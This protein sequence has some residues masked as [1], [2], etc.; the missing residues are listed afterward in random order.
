MF[1]FTYDI[2]TKILFGKGQIE[3]LGAE[4]K[5]YTDSVLLVYGGGSIKKN[6]VY[7]AAVKQLNDY[8]IRFE[9]LSGVAPNPRIESVVKGV[10]II[11]KNDLKGVL[12]VGGGSSIDCAKVIAGSVDYDG[13]PWD[14]VTAKANYKNILPIFS[15]LTLS[16]TGSEMDKNAVI[17][18]TELNAKVGTFSYDFLPKV[19]VM[20]PTY[21]FT[22][23]KEQTAAGTAD[24]MSHIME[25]YFSIDES[26]YISDRFAEGLLRA[27]IK[28]API[29]IENPEDYEARANLMWASTLGI[30]GITSMGKRI[31]WS[32]HRIEHMLSAYYDI[33]H[34]TGLAILTPNWMQ[35][36]LNESTLPRFVTYG[37]N[38]WDI[39]ASLSKE[40]IAKEAIEKTR[41]FFISMGIP[42]N[43]SALGI[44]ETYI[45][46][47]AIRSHGPN[48][49]QNG[50]WPI[51]VSDISNII[52]NSL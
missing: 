25:S 18:N 46:E 1:D 8:G 15:V 29:A 10:D 20:D 21:T 44:D 12:A 9:E 31:P 28:Y 3:K 2:P 33:T 43:L 11:R 4:I 13:D 51:T 17:S 14:L 49:L 23:P 30:N 48:G 45:D 7:D 39:D 52:K 16:A 40:E 50:F 6:G 36:V 42:D 34:G 26:A 41:A 35:Y 5:K 19:S 24:I 32:V 22:V 37:I 47:M 38:V 27:C